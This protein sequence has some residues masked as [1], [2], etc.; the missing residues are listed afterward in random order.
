MR[1]I[2][3]DASSSTVG[4]A[5][6]DYNEISNEKTLVYCDYFKPSKK[7]NLFER[8]SNTR[9]TIIAILSEYKPDLIS[10]EDIVSFMPGSSTSKTILILTAFNRMVG[11]SCFDHLKHPPSLFNVMSIRHGLKF[12]S[13]LPKKEEMPELVGKHLNITFPMESDKNGKLLEENYDKADSVAVALFTIKRLS[14]LRED[15]AKGIDFRLGKSK[16]QIAS[17]KKHYK[18]CQLEFREMTGYEYK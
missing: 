8:L 5:V 10:I 16:K 15:L 13:Q 6:L 4:Y 17:W 9:K 1:I 12:D 3:F 18:E 2:G 14:V 7:G 11:L